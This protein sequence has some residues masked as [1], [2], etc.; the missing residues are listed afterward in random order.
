MKRV[1]EN[2]AAAVTNFG[3]TALRNRQNL[4]LT[5]AEFRQ[6]RISFSMFGE[7][8]AVLRWLA[9]FPTIPKVYVDA[10]CYE[11]I[12]NSN[13]LLLHKAGWRGLNVDMSPEHIA[14]FNASRPNDVNVAAAL[15]SKVE[16][17]NAFGYGNT[18]TNTDRL[19]KA[20]Q[21]YLKSRASEEPLR[22][23]SV[24]TTTLDHILSETPFNQVSYLNIDCEGSDFDVLKGFD[25]RRRRPVVITIEAMKDEVEPVTSYLCEHGYSLEEILEITLLFVKPPNQ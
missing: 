25:L 10:G 24:Q 11:P 23:W 3:L 21:T 5:R 14:A 8:L 17:L 18:P 7:D 16:E 13:T 2:V 1:I 22:T 12:H 6:S 19:G 20:G 9:R 15:S 4:R